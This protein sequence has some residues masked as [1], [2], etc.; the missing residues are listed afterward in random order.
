MQVGALTS[1]S[2]TTPVSRPLPSPT[3]AQCSFAPES[4]SQVG[5]R[6]QFGSL[7]RIVRPRVSLR[8]ILGRK[9][10]SVWDVRSSVTALAEVGVAHGGVSWRDPY[11]GSADDDIVTFERRTNQVIVTSNHDMMLICEQSGQRFVWI[12]PHGRKL[13]Q[14]EQVLLC[15][16][17]IEQW[18]AILGQP[19]V[20]A[21]GLS[22]PGP[23]PSSLPR[24]PAWLGS[25]C[26][27]LTGND[28][29]E[30]GRRGQVANS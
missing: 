15:L 6:A 26:A 30:F 7:G 9:K 11:R 24:P 22:E 18:E 10:V 1:V 21:C 12:D 14:R 28:G 5:S 13:S 17:Q 27:S 20:F 25:G 8:P 23:W 4:C 29:C 3:R 16:T 19:V 2:V